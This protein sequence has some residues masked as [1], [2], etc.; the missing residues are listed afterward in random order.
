MAVEEV[1]KP[2]AWRA[3]ARGVRHGLLLAMGLCGALPALAASPTVDI[4]VVPVP[5]TVSY[6]RPSA[7]PPLVTRAAYEVRIVNQSTNTINDVRFLA[8]SQVIGATASA[9]FAE[10]IGASCQAT[11][12]AKLSVS[13]SLGQLRGGGGADATTSFVLVFNAPPAGSSISLA[14]TAAYGE[15]LGDS[16]GASHVDT[17]TGSA[18][19]LL[20]TPTATDVRSYIP[21]AGAKIFTGLNG[22]ATP[23]DP[24]T[25]TVVVPAFAKAEVVEDLDA[26]SCAPDLLICV[27][28]TLTIPGS[29]NYLLVTLR[30][31]VSTLKPGAKIA[32][33]VLRYQPGSVING[34]F[35][36][37]GTPVDIVACDLLPGR[38]PNATTRRC[39]D[40]RLEY[41]KKN[42][43]S[44]DY[45]GDWEFGL[46][47]LENG[48]VSW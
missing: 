25:T 47:A 44:A 30:R 14:W 5:A 12:A 27:R 28:S 33:A 46:K 40:Y 38:V 41:T 1:N 26:N 43:P 45:L 31:D 29:F 11:D 37:S 16:T 15:G 3:T 21:T 32:N 9:P 4:S 13:C 22:I 18:A 17:Q 20:G 39:V 6:S 7:T 48:R 23:G 2:R 10:A 24:W 34:E 35:V 42:S 8:T 36:P 19:T